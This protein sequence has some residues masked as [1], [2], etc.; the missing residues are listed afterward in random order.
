MRKEITHFFFLSLFISLPFISSLWGAEKGEKYI[1]SRLGLTLEAAK[2]IAASAQAKAQELGVAVAIVIVDEAGNLK[3]CYL[4]DNQ[5]ITALEW[6][7]ARALSSY[8]FRKP[9]SSGEFKVWNI[10]GRT[11]ILGVPGGFPLLYKGKLLGAIGVS[12][13][14]GKEDDIVA[15]AGLNRFKSLLPK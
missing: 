9:T 6:A 13:T 3:L 7:K 15:Q 2:E 8:E 5:T 12:G 14:K 4:M 10:A 11:M 1:V